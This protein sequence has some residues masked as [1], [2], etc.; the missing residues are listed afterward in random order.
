MGSK[1]LTPTRVGKMT[2]KC[3]LLLLL[4][5]SFGKT[6]RANVTVFRTL[7]DVV[8]R[9]IPRFHRARMVPNCWLGLLLE[10]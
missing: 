3:L 7:D 2:S 9:H 10:Q 5:L 8:L 1:R 4:L 6:Q